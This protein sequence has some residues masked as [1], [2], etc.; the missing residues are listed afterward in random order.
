[1]T[2]V[3]TCALPI[4][5]DFDFSTPNPFSVFAESRSQSR[6]SL[7]SALI[8]LLVA[9]AL[10]I[11][12]GFAHFSWQRHRVQRLADDFADCSTI[13]KLHRLRQLNDYEST[14]RRQVVLAMAD[15]DP[16]VSELAFELTKAT[17]TSWTTL[18]SESICNRRANLATS[19]RKAAEEISENGREANATRIRQTAQSLIEAI[20]A[21]TQGS[22]VELRGQNEATLKVAKQVLAHVSGTAPIDKDNAAIA[23][24]PLRPLPLD[25]VSETSGT[26][27]QWPPDGSTAP[28]LYRGTTKTLKK[29]Q[30]ADAALGQTASV[31]NSPDD[32]TF[33][34]KLG[35]A[36]DCDAAPARIVKPSVGASVSTQSQQKTQRANANRLARQLHSVSRR[37]RLRAVA[38]LVQRDDADSIQL[39]RDRLQVE[40]DDV[41]AFRIRRRLDQTPAS[42]R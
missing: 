32:Q 5:D 36:E 9:I 2:G 28:R 41:V 26:W 17:Q 4:L 16:E 33:D 18:P 25:A 40:R 3:Q 21:E 19:L 12:A 23:S 10:F 37:D 20:L 22:P 34:G 35:R 27:T 15:T 1:V 31:G 6:R 14:G 42:A 11:V 7:K 30:S 8:F 24:S 38:E 39:L 13:E 29:L